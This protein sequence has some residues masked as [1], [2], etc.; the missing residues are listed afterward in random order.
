MVLP[1]ERA[2]STDDVDGVFVSAGL[3]AVLFENVQDLGFPL[4]L[5]CHQRFQ[6]ADSDAVS[7]ISALVLSEMLT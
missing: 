4:G 2:E 5:G 7:A 1:P 3:A 6:R